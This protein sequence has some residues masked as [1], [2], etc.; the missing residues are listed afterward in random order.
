M[1]KYQGNRDDVKVGEQMKISQEVRVSI[2]QDAQQAM[3]ENGQHIQTFSG[4]E[5]KRYV[6]P[7]WPD[8]TRS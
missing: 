5:K 6:L 1:L 3:I 8:G 2:R 7:V 4:K